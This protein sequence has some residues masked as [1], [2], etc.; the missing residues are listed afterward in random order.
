MY[1]CRETDPVVVLLYWLTE[2]HEVDNT[3]FLVGVID[4]L[5][6]LARHNLSGSLDYN[7]RNYIEKW[8]Q[9]VTMA[10]LTQSGLGV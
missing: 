6:A 10:A 3:E 2:K 5:I 4:Y 8:F 1:G 7:D 9:T